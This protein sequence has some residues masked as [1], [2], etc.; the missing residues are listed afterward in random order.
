MLIVGI[1]HESR[2]LVAH[3]SIKYSTCEQSHQNS[4]KQDIDP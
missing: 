4:K 3:S 2:N 1:L